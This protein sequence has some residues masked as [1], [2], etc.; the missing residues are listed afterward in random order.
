MQ[1]EIQPS[2]LLALKVWW[3]WCWRVMPL[4]LIGSFVA[5]FIVILIDYLIGIDQKTGTTISA[6]LGGAIG[7]YLSVYIFYRLMVK[8]FGKYRLAVLEK[9]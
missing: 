9:D 7:L 5:G 3:S 4:A 8:G 6:V 2:L 1:R